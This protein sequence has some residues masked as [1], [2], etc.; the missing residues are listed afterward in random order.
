M[1]IFIFFIAVTGAII[2]SSFITSHYFYYH[3]F[4]PILL[5][6]IISLI[7]GIVLG[8]FGKPKQ[9]TIILNSL[10]FVLLSF[11]AL[12]NLWITTFGK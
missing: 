7:I 5:V 3:Y 2:E 11:L 6:E 9:I 10:F 12:L 4:K 8:S 1:V